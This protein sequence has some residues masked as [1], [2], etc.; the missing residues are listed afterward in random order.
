MKRKTLLVLLMIMLV[1]IPV[2]S[3]GDKEAKTA[4]KVIRIAEQVPGLITPGVWD[5]QVFSMNSSMYEYLAEINAETGELDP[6]LATD[7]STENGTKWTFNLRK[8]VKFHDGTDFTSADVKFSLERTQDPALGHLKKQDF[9]VVSS[10]ETPDDYTVIINL[11]E[12]RPTFVYQLTDYN[13]A[14]LSSE[15]DYAKFGESKPMGTGP[16][17]LSQYIPKE[18]IAM[19]KNTEYWDPALPKVDKLLIYFVGDID[20]SVSM[21]EADRVDVV[22]FLT[23]VIKNRLSKIDGIKVISPYQEQ[24]FV[25]MNVDEKPWDDNRAR[26][27]FKYAIDPE[28]LAKSV[29]QMEIG[30]GAEYNE[31]PIMN[32]LSE[33]KALPLRVR[34]IEKAKALLAEAGYPNGVTVELYYASDHPFGKELAQTL[35]ELAAPAGFNLDLKGYTRDV[36]LSQYWLNVPMSITG[37]GGRVDPSMLLALAFKGGGAW[38]ESHVDDPRINALIDKIAAELDEAKRTS[39]YHELQDIFYE[40]GALLNVQVPYLVATNDRVIDFK[41]PLTM[42]PQYKYTDIR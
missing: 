40:E 31:T 8:G 9:E 6:V 37:W 27:A 20:A 5:G 38:N 3:K 28:I 33:Y 13:M 30:N 19:V 36:Y 42:L 17:K 4:E 22:N 34:D 35:K 16:F 14:I 18:S 21:L 1:T 15:Y 24:R 32:M 2:F 12:P 39:Y 25:A 29:T 11:K 7:W 26:L 23:P 41:Q 10:I